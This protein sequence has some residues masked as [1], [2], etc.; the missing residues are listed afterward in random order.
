MNS[1]KYL[2][3]SLKLLAFFCIALLVLVIIFFAITSITPIP[4]SFVI[5]KIFDT[6]IS[7]E[8]NN[9]FLYENE[10]SL[11]KN[12]S[13]P[14]K[15]KNNVA[16]LYLPKEGSNH[17]LIIWI[18]G[19]AYVGG[20]KRD[21][22]EYATVLAANGYAVFSANYERAPESKYPNQ[23]RQIEEIYKFAA[24]ESEKYNLDLNNLFLAGDSAGAH[25]ISQFALIQTSLEYANIMNFNQ[26]MDIDTIKGILLYC[27]PY[28]VRKIDEIKN[29]TISFL[30]SQ[31]AWAYFGSKNWQRDFGDVATIKN[32][33]TAKFP[34][35]FITDGNSS[36]K[37]HALELIEELRKLNTETDYFFPDNKSS[38]H[39]YQFKL[40]TDDGM[41]SIELTLN[42][43]KEKQK[44]D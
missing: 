5:R 1:S 19:G 23:I 44:T 40:D 3:I 29:K 25:M 34:P 20:D 14:S 35:V 32:H 37:E 31:A 6:P 26:V 16:D 39:E 42:F 33:V 21:V 11:I 43:L 38:L 7:T 2:R 36:F 8:P 15:Y 9:Y 28:N 13:Y 18:H 22:K 24:K 17:P 41:R 10:V 4:I 12:I 30:F 27:G